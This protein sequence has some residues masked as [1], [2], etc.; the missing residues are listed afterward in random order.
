MRRIVVLTIAVVEEKIM[1]FAEHCQQ[2]YYYYIPISIYIIIHIK[3]MIR[4]K[5][6]ILNNLSLG[7]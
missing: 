2:D 6:I 4:N 7:T 3:K 5:A 1:D